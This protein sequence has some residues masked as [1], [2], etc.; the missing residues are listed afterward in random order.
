MEGKG[1]WGAQFF[2]YDNDGDLD[3][4]AA[5]G[6]AEE[7]ISQYPLLL[8]NDGTGHFKN[9]GMEH[10][11]YFKTKRSGRS[12]AVWD[13][14]NDGDVD[15]I[16]SHLDKNGTPALL[17]NDGGNSNHWLGVTLEGKGGSAVSAKVTL[18]AAG[19][20]QVM[21]NQFATSYLANNDPRLHF[22]L[23]QV[24]QID[25]LEINWSDGKKETYRNIISDRYITIT[26]GAGLTVQV[27]KGKRLTPQ[28]TSPKPKKN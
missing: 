1:S 2:D 21:I 3:I 17:R 14:D 5:N 28:T 8:E 10:G 7:L 9:V 12:L 26:E 20:K 13:F 15:I 6:T 24:K 22:G 27:A 18:T 16:I 23:G 11:D 19:R 4:I 25:S